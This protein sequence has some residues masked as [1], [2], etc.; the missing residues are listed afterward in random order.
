MEVPDEVDDL[1][2]VNVAFAWPKWSV[3][4]FYLNKNVDLLN[5]QFLWRVA[6][7]P[8]STPPPLAYGPVEILDFVENILYRFIFNYKL[9]FRNFILLR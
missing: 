6:A 8:T 4:I 3:K 9:S 1:F 5:F 2:M 7:A